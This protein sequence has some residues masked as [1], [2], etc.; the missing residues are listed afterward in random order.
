LRIRFP[1]IAEGTD[2]TTNLIEQREITRTRRPPGY[3]RLPLKNRNSS[4]HNQL[5]TAS[6]FTIVSCMRPCLPYASRFSILGVQ[7]EVH[8][9]KDRCIEKASLRRWLS[10]AFRAKAR[11]IV[12]SSTSARFPGALR[13]S[14]GFFEELPIDKTI[15]GPLGAAAS[16]VPRFADIAKVIYPIIT[17]VGRAFQLR[18]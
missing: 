14:L 8:F 1:S 3:E 10:F 17:N 18:Q 16:R 6:R 12:R 5:A 2:L 7:R 11:R 4:W 15:P 9:R 13:G